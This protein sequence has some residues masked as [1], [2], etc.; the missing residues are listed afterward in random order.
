[1]TRV[2]LSGEGSETSIEKGRDS[3]KKKTCG[4]LKT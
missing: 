4:R 2:L 3:R 1:M